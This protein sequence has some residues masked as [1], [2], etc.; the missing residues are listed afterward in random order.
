[1]EP[2]AGAQQHA[3]LKPLMRGHLS[4]QGIF[5]RGGKGKPL[6]YDHRR[7]TVVNACH[8]NLHLPSSL[9]S[10][11]NRG[12]P[13]AGLS[14]SKEPLP[15]CANYTKF[16]PTMQPENRFSEAFVPSEVPEKDLA[17][18]LLPAGFPPSPLFRND[19]PNPRLSVPWVRRGE[20]GEL[21]CCGKL[22][23]KES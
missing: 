3:A 21:Y 17:G 5:F 19:H 10:Q 16:P 6:P 18:S 8:K 11:K 15:F 23:K 12:A 4:H 22:V 14:G 20:N 9:V 13:F 1:M 7:R 2:V